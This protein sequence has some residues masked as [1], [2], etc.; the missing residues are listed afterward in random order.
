MDDWQKLPFQLL[1]AIDDWQSWH[2]QLPQSIG[3]PNYLRTPLPAGHEQL[4]LPAA[5]TPTGHRQLT[6]SFRILQAPPQVQH[7][8]N[9]TR[10]DR[11]FRQHHLPTRL[12]ADTFRNAEAHELAHPSCRY[13]DQDRVWAYN[14]RHAED[15]ALTWRWWCSQAGC[16]WMSGA[17]CACCALGVCPE[18]PELAGSASRIRRF[19]ASPSGAPSC[20]GLEGVTCTFPGFSVAAF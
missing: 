4:T 2:F 3:D 9:E 10:Y 12:L 15:Q 7:N 8:M 14:P 11:T 1:Q 5:L 18:C 20:T 17:S 19:C 6:T 16:V 13:G